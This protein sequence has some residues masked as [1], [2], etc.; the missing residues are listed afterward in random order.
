MGI[1]YDL[2]DPAELIG[3]ARRFTNEVLVNKF[4]GQQYLPNKFVDD[5]EY[6]LK[7]EG[8][9][10]VD[11][12]LYRSWDTPP[13][14]TGRPGTAKV[15]GEIAPV[16]RSIALGE[17]EGLR[18]RRLK[19]T[20]GSQLVDQIFNDA[21]RMIRAVEGRIEVA[22]FDAL[23][24]GKVILLEPNGLD[25]VADYGMPSDQKV[26]PGVAWTVA[27]S[28]TATPISDL[29]AINALSLARNGAGIG[30]IVMSKSR[31]PALLVN[32]EVR[33]YIA[34]GGNV[35]VRVRLSDVQ[36]VLGE[37][38][39]PT[40]EFVDTMVRVDGVQKRV[41]PPEFVLCLPS[42]DDPF[43]TTLYGPTAE[44]VL[45]AEKGYI[46]AKQVRGVA[47]VVAQNDSPVQTFTTG[48]AVA[49]PVVPN[50][51][52]LFT[53]KVDVNSGTGVYDQF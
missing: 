22:R 46:T 5:I 1:L 10:D 4:T 47:A 33:D 41:L 7:R 18:L 9:T 25:I 26:T 39:L 17:E 43:G 34:G 2:A 50:P 32:D 11:I 40:I 53:L 42:T 13:P 38:D 12:A 3:Y 21:E 37:Q 6:A 23:I 31:V 15:R 48:T 49:L 35:P 20:N 24:D 45:L 28:A 16:S 8:L 36:A 19:S 30:K 52:L 27:N 29:L 51:E 44:A 14:M